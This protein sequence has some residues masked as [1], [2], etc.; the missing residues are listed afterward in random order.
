MFGVVWEGR[1]FHP[2]GTGCWPGMRMQSWCKTMGAGTWGR[3]GV[4][5]LAGD[6]V[7]VRLRGDLSHS[8]L[9]NSFGGGV[10]FSFFALGCVFSRTAGG[11]FFVLFVMFGQL[12]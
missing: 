5:T 7:C 12:R 2:C 6:G 1:G 3:R 4:G 9:S 11:R 8:P 10:H